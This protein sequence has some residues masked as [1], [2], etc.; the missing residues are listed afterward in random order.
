MLQN[1]C[2]HRIQQVRKSQTRSL[3]LL[4]LL[5]SGLK[6]VATPFFTSSIN[7]YIMN[8]EQYFTPAQLPNTIFWIA[9]VV[10]LLSIFI[11][12]LGKPKVV[13]QSFD[14]WCIEKYLKEASVIL[15]DT[16]ID[17]PTRLERLRELT[18]AYEH[19]FMGEN[20][21]YN[22]KSTTHKS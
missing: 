1:L 14:N 19:M 8:I 2:T 16:K 21:I 4:P 15:N 10:F 7:S 22:E 13:R 5:R 12:S 17:H 9:L 11:G 6:I 3:V 20:K 18:N